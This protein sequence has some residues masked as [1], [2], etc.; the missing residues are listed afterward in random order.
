ME[1]FRIQDKAE[2]I[3]IDSS[4]VSWTRAVKTGHGSEECSNRHA[5]E[6]VCRRGG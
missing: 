1:D 3:V 4:R 6:L 5:I 2:Q